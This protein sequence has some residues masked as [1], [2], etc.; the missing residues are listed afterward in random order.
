MKNY[1]GT[2]QA[3]LISRRTGI[4]RRWIIS[5]NHHPERRSGKD[6]RSRQRHDFL[7]PIEQED[8]NAKEILETNEHDCHEE[9]DPIPLKR[10][11]SEKEILLLPEITMTNKAFDK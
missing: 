2:P 10:I 7:P 4:D 1:R 3:S 9:A 6:R 5:K 11:V 8:E